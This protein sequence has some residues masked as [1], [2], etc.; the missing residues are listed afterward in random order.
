MGKS[1]W[2]R[3]LPKCPTKPK[4]NKI[5]PHYKPWLVAVS[6]VISPYVKKAQRDFRAN[7]LCSRS[8]KTK[9]PRLTLSYWEFILYYT[10][11]CFLV[12]WERQPPNAIPVLVS[13][14]LWVAECWLELISLNCCVG[15]CVLE[16]VVNCHRSSQTRGGHRQNQFRLI[17]HCGTPRFDGGFS[18]LRISHSWLCVFVNVRGMQRHFLGRWQH[19]QS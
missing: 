18:R 4:N 7:R 11:Q 6:P 5:C 15:L 1:R 2:V 12:F 14:K 9:K 3:H 8:S 19:Q 16:I 10:N 17:N 13:C